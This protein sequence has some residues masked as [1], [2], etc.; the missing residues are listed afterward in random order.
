MMINPLPGDLRARAC[1]TSVYTRYSPRML[2]AFYG[3]RTVPANKIMLIISSMRPANDWPACWVCM[4]ID[5]GAMG[6]SVV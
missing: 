3:R 6:W 4:I 1:Q 5:D 2:N